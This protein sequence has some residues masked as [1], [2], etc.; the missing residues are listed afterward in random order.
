MP[1][2]ERAEV[3]GNNVAGRHS[4]NRDKQADDRDRKGDEIDTHAEDGHV[5][6][7]QASP[8][9][10]KKLKMVHDDPS[11]RE[12]T[13]SETRLKSLKNGNQANICHHLLDGLYIE[14]SNF[15]HQRDCVTYQ[16][17][18]VWGIFA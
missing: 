17:Y 2:R 1:S 7:T 16:N 4:D 10:M 13:H 9:R 6:P 3:M 8:T 18:D 14:N 5:T 15:K 11:T 12:R